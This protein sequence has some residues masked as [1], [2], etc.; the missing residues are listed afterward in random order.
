MDLEQ[1]P[2]RIGP[3]CK[4]IV[5]VHLYGQPLNMDKLM[6]ICGERNVALI[7]DGAQAHGARYGEKRVGSFGTI[8]CFSFYPTKNLAAFGDGGAVLTQDPKLAARVRRLRN[9]GR[10]SRYEHSEVGYNY[11]MDE[12]QGRV[13]NTK[14][15]H[16]DKWNARRRELVRKY[17]ERLKKLPLFIPKVATSAEPVY[18]L[19]PVGLGCRDE[20]ALYLREHQIETGVYYPV[21]LHLQPAFR[22]LGHSEGDFPVAERIAKETLSLPL[23][24]FLTDDQADFVCRRIGEFFEDR[25]S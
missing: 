3:K 14:L 8:S 9:H 21:P 17:C 15:G 22:S 7:E 11:R 12:L 25:H 6:A 19:F 16:L 1:L 2:H 10:V 24:P 20:L 4:A 5:A 18:H 13:L 23:H